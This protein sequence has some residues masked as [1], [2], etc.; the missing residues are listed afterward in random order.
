MKENLH[1]QKDMSYLW[2]G[3]LN[4]AKYETSQINLLSQCNSNPNSYSFGFLF[5]FLFFG[6]NQ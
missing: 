4:I 1:K 5:V 3:R 2:T 6:E